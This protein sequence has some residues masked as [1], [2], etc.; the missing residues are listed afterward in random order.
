MPE[1]LQSVSG[2]LVQ[3]LVVVA[4]GVALGLSWE[5]YGFWPLLL[6]GIP[7]LTLSVR[8][9]PLRRSFGLGYLFGLAMLAVS[10]SWLHVLGVWVAAL[11]ILFEAL[12]FGLLGV[13]LSLVSGL[14]WWPV[15]GAA[16]GWRWSS[17]TRGCRSGGSAG[18]GSPM[19]RST[20]RWPDSCRSSASPGSRSSSP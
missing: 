2:R 7:A 15:A 12:F 20:L 11:L 13:A 5:P 17:R 6:V 9:L 16:A 10:I 3:A 18:P 4:A 8:G 19:P 1:R 14:R